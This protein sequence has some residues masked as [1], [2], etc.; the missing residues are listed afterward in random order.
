[1]T[2]DPGR[3]PVS[4]EGSVSDAVVGDRAET[5]PGPGSGPAVRAG[6]LRL[7]IGDRLD[8]LRAAKQR[9]VARL[10]AAHREEYEVLVDD[11]LANPPA[12]GARP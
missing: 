2:I 9:A 11:E 6:L 5:T 12:I 3:C 10:K 1:M 8:V 7:P 4:V